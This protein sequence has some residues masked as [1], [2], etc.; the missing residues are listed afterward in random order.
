[1]RGPGD[2]LFRP[3]T[4]TNQTVVDN[5]KNKREKLEMY[6]SE[7][8]KMKSLLMNSA[9]IRSGMSTENEKPLN[10]LWVNFPTKCVKPIT[11]VEEMKEKLDYFSR[12]DDVMVV[13]YHQNNCTACNALDKVFEV[14]CHQATQRT[15]GLKFYEVNR[16]ELP[17]LTKGLVRYPQLKGFSGG[18]WTDIEFKPPSQFREEL[19][20]DIEKEV[21]ARKEEGTPVTALQAEEMYFSAAGPAMLEIAE[22]NLVLFYRKAQVR[23]HNYWKQV[24]VRRTW[25]FRKFIA[26]QIEE[27]VR[28]EWRTKS[29]FGEKV[30]YGPRIPDDFS[31]LS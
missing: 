5:I 28:D 15:P 29:I 23:L 9:G 6:Q 25:F 10:P 16:N 27:T 20:S 7:S 11:S 3:P 12:S 26:P 14:L 31:D 21:Q 13:R 19:Y 8:H 1:M 24:S 17:E 22:E 18:Q 4:N 2:D 30:V